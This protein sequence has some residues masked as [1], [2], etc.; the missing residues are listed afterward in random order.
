[1][2]TLCALQIGFLMNVPCGKLGQ[3]ASQAVVPLCMHDPDVASFIFQVK[4]KISDA[5]L[6]QGLPRLIPQAKHKYLSGRLVPRPLPDFILQ[7]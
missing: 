7:L 2:W 5:L 3:A 6:T 1:M 4:H